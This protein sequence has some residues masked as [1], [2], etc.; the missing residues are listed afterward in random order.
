MA[1]PMCQLLH[2]TGDDLLIH[3][4]QMARK[5][6]KRRWAILI[7]S[8]DKSWLHDDNASSS[9]SWFIDY[10]LLMYVHIFTN[11][12]CN[13]NEGINKAVGIGCMVQGEH[14]PIIYMCC[15]SMQMCCWSVSL[16]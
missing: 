13:G 16:F 6:S 7:N 4:W 3:F 12:L 5:S 14:A 11:M 9:V 8:C 15:C 1:I 2:V 10:R